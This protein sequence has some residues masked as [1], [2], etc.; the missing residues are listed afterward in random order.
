MVRTN[1]HIDR[2]LLTKGSFKDVLD[3]A[4]EGGG[5]A[6]FGRNQASSIGVDYMLDDLVFKLSPWIHEPCYDEE[7]KSKFEVRINM[8]YGSLKMLGLIKLYRKTL[9]FLRGRIVVVL[10]WLSYSCGRY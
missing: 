9:V 1:V 6:R 5:L 8:E 3:N 10:Y 7:E 4:V 2:E